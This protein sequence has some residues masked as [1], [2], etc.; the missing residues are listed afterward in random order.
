MCMRDKERQKAFLQA[1]APQCN[2]TLGVQSIPIFQA[3]LW[4][5][6]ED[7][8]VI[9]RQL[10]LIFAGGPSAVDELFNFVV[11]VPGCKAWGCL[12]S[13]TWL[14]VAVMAAETVL[15]VKI[16]C[17]T[18]MFGTLPGRLSA[19]TRQSPSR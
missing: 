2:R 1:S 5:P 3:V 9:Y 19:S 17:N 6:T 13:H 10:V 12:G 14:M 4:V 18:G 8:I 7:P 15:T 11:A 16:A